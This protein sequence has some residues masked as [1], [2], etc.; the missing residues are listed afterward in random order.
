LV[1]DPGAQNSLEKSTT[2]LGKFIPVLQYDICDIELG[3]TA[4]SLGNAPLVE[5]AETNAFSLL[6]DGAGPLG[7]ARSGLR[8]LTFGAPLGPSSRLS[9]PVRA[10]WSQVDIDLPGSREAHEMWS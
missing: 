7:P 1:P 4:S 2:E 9:S 5:D 6:C 8:Y 10:R 3:G